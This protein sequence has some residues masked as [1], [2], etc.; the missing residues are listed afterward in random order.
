M[1]LVQKLKM[2]PFIFFHKWIQSAW[3]K[4]SRARVRDRLVPFPFTPK[5]Q[6]TGPCSPVFFKYDSKCFYWLVQ[7]SFSTLSRLNH[8]FSKFKRTRALKQMLGFLMYSVF[9]NIKSSYYNRLNDGACNLQG[10]T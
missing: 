8:I 6:C 10:F 2:V 7:Q 3:L 1:C 4:S 9:I 5:D